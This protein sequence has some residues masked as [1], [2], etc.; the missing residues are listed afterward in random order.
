MR[1][2]IIALALAIPSLA[3][4]QQFPDSAIGAAV[5]ADNGEVVGH[6]DHV[7]RDGDGD[8]MAAEISNQE[9][10][11]A[12]YAPRA[13]VADAG[14]DLMLIVE[15]NDEPRPSTILANTRTR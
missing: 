13:L 10:A 5:V 6:V 1:T 14:D 15:R 4:A 12:P 9:P 11:S 3:E 2:I 7:V 8:I